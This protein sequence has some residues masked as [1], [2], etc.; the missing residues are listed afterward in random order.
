MRVFSLLL[1]IMV[2][3]VIVAVGWL[4][5]S[6]GDVQ[7]AAAHPPEQRLT[8][9]PGGLLAT[10]AVMNQ[11]PTLDVAA[12]QAT[13]EALAASALEAN[14][15]VPGAEQTAAA[16]L[17]YDAASGSSPD[18]MVATAEMYATQSAVDPLAVEAAIEA[19]LND[20]P[21]YWYEEA[22]LTAADLELLLDAWTTAGNV[23]VQWQGDQLIAS[24]TYSEVGLNALIDASIMLYEYPVT[25]ANVDLIPD[26]AVID[27][28]GFTSDVLEQ[29]GDLSVHVLLA[30][31]E[32]AGRVEIQV[33]SA[34]FNGRQIPQATLDDAEKL[35]ADSAD[36]FNQALSLVYG[37]EYAINELTITEVDLTAVVTVLGAQQYQ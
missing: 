21:E 31:D 5:L 12:A 37:V 9:V 36:V 16:I 14:V 23:N 8:R 25:D 19:V 13:A 1:G 15:P 7:P 11:R 30:P 17:N 27:V 34:A 2:V 24:V 28:Y 3:A 35:L 22:D 26:G 4:S 20:V 6:L 18:I 10:P 29:S 33:V 32:E